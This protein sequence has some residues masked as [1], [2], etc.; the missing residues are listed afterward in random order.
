MATI[1]RILN[2]ANDCFYVGSTIN[3][4]RRRWEHW[5]SLK[6]G[7]HHC[8]ALQAAWNEFGEDAFEF[9]VLEEVP[10]S[11]DLATI[12]ETYLMR[13]VGSTKCYNT[14]ESAHQSP[15]LMPRVAAKISRTLQEK[16]A[17]DPS[18]QPRLG[19]VHTEGTKAKISAKV[20]RALAEGRGGKFV[21]SE[22][23]RRRMSEALKG[24]QNA[25]G[26]I[27]TEE[28]RRKLAEANIGNQ[29]WLGKQHTEESKLKMSK[30][31]VEATTN[32]EFPSLT[33]V[34]SH[35]GFKMPTL[36]RALVSGKPIQRGPHKGLVFKYK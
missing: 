36:R 23:T 25:R 29:H 22:E 1:Y 12:E 34:I 33:A 5:D 16:Y 21:P 9:E 11:A 24:N 18:Y 4:R 8:A 32:A 35:Y 6:K 14:A 3:H 26:H 7:Q 31:V 19:K 30:A 17:T 15:A 2:V 27:R 20:Q 10:E 13:H 28:H